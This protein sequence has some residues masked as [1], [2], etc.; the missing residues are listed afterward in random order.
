[1]LNAF[2]NPKDEHDPL[3]F[4]PSASNFAA[5]LDGEKVKIFN[6]Y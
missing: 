5:N 4:K 3:S 6:L 2:F 1:M